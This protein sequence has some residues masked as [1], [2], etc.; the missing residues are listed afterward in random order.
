VEGVFAR[1]PVLASRLEELGLP[2]L[3]EEVL[4]RRVVGRS[5]RAKAFVNGSLVTVG[6]LSRLMRGTVDIAGQHE[7]VSLFD[8]G[9][10]RALLDRHGR[11]EEQLA[12]YARDFAAVRRWR[13]AWSPWAAT[14]PG[15]ASAPSS[16]ASS[17]M[18]SPS[19]T[20]SR[21]RT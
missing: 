1:S 6:V 15:C 3:G 16:S 21:A 18:K 4:V 13:R 17:W 5:G 2:D 10:H 9:L 14:R 7:H 11:L 20:R 8:S 12:A 19:W